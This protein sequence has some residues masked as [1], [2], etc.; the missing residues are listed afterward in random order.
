MA[1]AEGCLHE[2]GTTHM[3]AYQQKVTPL[4][5]DSPDV[6]LCR[7]T[8]ESLQQENTQLKERLTLQL[9]RLAALQQKIKPYDGNCR[10]SLNRGSDRSSIS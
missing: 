7:R 1:G 5:R 6:F 9:E 4:F 8:I 2:E 10:V 3:P